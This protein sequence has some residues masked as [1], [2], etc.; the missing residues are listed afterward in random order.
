MWTVS[1]LGTISLSDVFLVPVIMLC[2][3]AGTTGII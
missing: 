1:E 2:A 3:I